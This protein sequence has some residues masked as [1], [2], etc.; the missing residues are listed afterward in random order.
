MLPQRVSRAD[1][2]RI[3]LR[4]FLVALVVATVISGTVAVVANVVENQKFND[5]N[6]VTIPTNVLS[7]KGKAGSPTNFLIIGSDS[8]AFVDTPA[9]AKAFG[10]AKDVGTGRSDVMM[11][12]HTEPQLGTAFVVSFP[13]DTE[14]AIPGHG[15]D[16]LNAAFAY[17]GPALTIKTFR[18]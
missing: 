14:V 7:P 1:S 10:S 17:G 9:Q 8:R 6:T 18:E 16:K 12:V 4:R 13:R 2:I 11:I 3:F 15:H 5:I